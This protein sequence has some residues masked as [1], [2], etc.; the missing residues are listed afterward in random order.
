MLPFFACKV[1]P[2][3]NKLPGVKSLIHAIGGAGVPNWISST[4]VDHCGPVNDPL[5]RNLPFGF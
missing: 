1:S 4:K 3:F 5:D 2:R